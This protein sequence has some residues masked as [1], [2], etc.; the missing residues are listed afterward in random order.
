M[1]Y[2]SVTRQVLPSI[3]SMLQNAKQLHRAQ[4]YYIISGLRII[5]HGNTDNNLELHCIFKPIFVCKMCHY[6][7]KYRYLAR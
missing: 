6:S 2:E 7:S 1:E 5:G 4:F 3:E